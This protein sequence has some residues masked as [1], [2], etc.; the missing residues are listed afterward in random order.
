MVQNTPV[1]YLDEVSHL[2]TG[3]GV[4]SSAFEEEFIRVSDD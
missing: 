1:D 2:L 3:S 4:I